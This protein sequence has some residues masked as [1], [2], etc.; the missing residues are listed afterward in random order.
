LDVLLSYVTLS[1]TNKTSTTVLASDELKKLVP[2]IDG[3]SPR[4]RS[5]SV[6]D[7]YKKEFS[8]KNMKPLS[9][10]KLADPQNTGMVS[11]ANLENATRKVF[12]LH[13]LEVI[14]ELLTAFKGAPGGVIKR[15][16]FELV[17]NVDPSTQS[18]SPVKA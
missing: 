9:L 11:L 13:K 6:V 17:F 18:P 2:G 3:M 7:W 15:D 4:T 16:Q 5:Q 1:N 12:P 10:F 8:A 14:Q